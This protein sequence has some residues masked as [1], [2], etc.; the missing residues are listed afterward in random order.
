MAGSI[1]NA[2]RG[3]PALFPAHLEDWI[4]EDHRVCV[5]DLF[6]DKLDLR[7]LGFQRGACRHW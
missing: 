4:N 3:Q 5:V 2:N 1:N 6:V 7:A